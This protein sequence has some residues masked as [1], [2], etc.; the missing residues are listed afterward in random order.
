MSRLTFPAK[1]GTKIAFGLDHAMGWFFQKFDRHG[2]CEIDED[3]FFDPR[4]FNR[5][6]LLERIQEHGLPSHALEL[7]MT[8]IALDLDPAKSY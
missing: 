8:K 1:D 5:G 2:D 3:Q 4:D 7:A 6:K